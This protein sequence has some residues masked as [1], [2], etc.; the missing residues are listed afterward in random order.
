MGPRK[1]IV[2]Y[3]VVI[4]I[5][6]AFVVILLICAACGKQRGQVTQLS[7]APPATEQPVVGQQTDG[8]RGV[9]PLVMALDGCI[10]VSR[11]VS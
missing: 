11:E 10:A 6:L 4:A 9:L 2:T 1:T 5:T 8:D 7:L 3:R